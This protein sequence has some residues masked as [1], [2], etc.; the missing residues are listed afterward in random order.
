MALSAGALLGSNMVLQQGMAV[1]VWG[2]AAPGASVE[3]AFKGQKVA[4]KADGAGDWKVKLAALAASSEPAEMVISAT[5]AAGKKETL[6]LSNVLVG[7]VWFCSGQSNMQWPLSQ[8]NNPVQEIAAA[9][10]PTIRLFSVPKVTAQKPTKTLTSGAWEA[11][12]SDTAPAFSAVGYFF[13]RE[14]HKKLGVPVGLINSSW[15]GTLVEA[16]TSREGLLSDPEG[17]QIAEKFEK[18]LPNM[19]ER[20]EEWKK[21]VAAITQ[22]TLD[23]KNEGYGKGWAG[24]TDPTTGEWDE[25]NIP[26]TWQARGVAG[27]GILWFRK[28]V[29]IP[30]A[31]A[32]KDLVL[33][34]GAT[35]KSDTT[36]FNNEKVGG[37][38][39]KDNPEAWSFHREYPVPAKLVKAGRAVI[40]CRVHSDMYAGGMTGPE[41]VMRLACPSVPGAQPI[42]LAGV[43]K[44]TH[45][46]NYGR[47]EIPM[48]PV[49][50][51]HQ[52]APSRLYNAMVEPAVPMAIRGAIWYQ[53]ESNAGRARQY[54]SLMKTIIKDWR[55][56]FEQ[57]K[58]PFHIVQ[59][60]NYM[61]PNDVPMSSNWAETREAQ[62]MAMELG[63][64]GLA[65]TIDIGEG[66]DIHPKNKQDV[67]LRLALA[68][69]HQTYGL[70]DVVH[71]GPMYKKHEAKDGQ[72][73]VYFD[74]A[75]GL[76]AKGGEVKGFS[77]AGADGKHAWAQGRI[78][79]DAVVLT[80]AKV[81]KPVAVRYAWAD[82]PACNLYN[83]A[84]L[85]AVPFR[86]DVD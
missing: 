40:A 44:W 80:S 61:A 33:T 14:L 65:V 9:N 69:L 46:A 37:V 43:W 84:G 60:A 19:T 51:D 15:G 47:V 58:L 77:V 53:G 12:T 30:A 82:N 68:A 31:W 1:P 86:T 16:W 64:V 62:A 3:V 52:H 74:H 56:K 49:G 8:A 18:D 21:D 2:K 20:T 76:T 4:G 32:G 73:K 29:E 71:S 55:R 10:Y 63:K 85:P 13:G 26:G 11:C 17:K 59:L 72:V 35:D 27:S 39:M 5:D 7:E 38:S 36:Y 83:A 41:S 50:P 6:K 57:E 81:A 25:M 70:T 66:D 23:L 24:V 78:E 54:R 48:V 28:A 22:R 79:G 34:I 42:A 75:K 45:E 67:G